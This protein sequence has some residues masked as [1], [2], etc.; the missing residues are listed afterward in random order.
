VTFPGRAEPDFF[1]VSVEGVEYVPLVTRSHA[2]IAKLDITFLRREEPGDI[3]GDGGDLDNRLK[4]LFDALRIPHGEQ[5]IDTSI[6]SPR[7][8]YCLLEDDALI[9]K[10]SI[11]TQRYLGPLLDGEKETDVALDIRVTVESGRPRL[12]N[13]IF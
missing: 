13:V 2:L 12:G 5:E 10:L 7:R 1:Y 11:D 4:S 6:D 3:V 9:T 8:V